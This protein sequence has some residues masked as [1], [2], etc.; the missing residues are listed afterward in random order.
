MGIFDE[1][2]KQ[3]MFYDTATKKIYDVRK[4]I[5]NLKLQKQTSENLISL[6]TSK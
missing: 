1:E 5:D 4:E 6:D 3:F 2:D